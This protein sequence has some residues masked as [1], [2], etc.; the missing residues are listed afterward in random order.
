MPPQKLRSGKQKSK[1]GETENWL[2]VCRWNKTSLERKSGFLRLQ[3][4]RKTCKFKSS[5]IRPIKLFSSAKNEKGQRYDLTKWNYAQLRDFINTSSD[6]EM[7]KSCREE[8]A[9][10]LQAYH[11]WKDQVV[12]L[13]YKVASLVN[14]E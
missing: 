1:N 5:T 13:G 10:R 11:K 12:C 6:V 3:I 4:G 7:I 9:R 8:F 14:V 2:R